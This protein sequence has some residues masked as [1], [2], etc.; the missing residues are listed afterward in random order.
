MF[1]SKLKD[2]EV[3]VIGEDETNG[4]SELLAT[5]D[6]N[7]ARRH[8]RSVMVSEDVRTYHGIVHPAKILPSGLHNVSAFV[9]YQDSEDPTTG[10]VFESSST[11]TKGLSEEI[12]ELLTG[13]LTKG[14]IEEL[15]VLYG[16][17][18]QLGLTIEDTDIDEEMMSSWESVCIDIRRAERF[19]AEA[20]GV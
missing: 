8:L 3:I 12:M 7:E 14:D 4:L 20:G 10:F 13:G 15:Y 9:I 5:N 11:N 17:E 1:L 2:K 6:I 18:L 16:K 19:V